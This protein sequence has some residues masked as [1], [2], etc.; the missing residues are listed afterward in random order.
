[1]PFP[2]YDCAL[3]DVRTEKLVATATLPLVPRVGEELWIGDRKDTATFGKYRVAT[4][5]YEINERHR[6]R[7]GHLSGVTIHLEPVV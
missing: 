5:R 3:I 4:V 7:L 6:V 2:L 1:M